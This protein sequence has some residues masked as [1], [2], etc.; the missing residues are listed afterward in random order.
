MERAAGGLVQGFVV[1]HGGRHYAYENQCP[2][3]GAALDCG[4]GRFFTDDGRHLACTTHGAVFAPATGVCVEG[5]C[6]GARL[7][8]LPIVRDGPDLVITWPS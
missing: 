4:T 1:N 2:H 3:A 8:P 7:R 6:P 5:P